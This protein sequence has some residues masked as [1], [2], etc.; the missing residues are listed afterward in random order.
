MFPG[1]GSS[2]CNRQLSIYVD[3]IFVNSPQVFQTLFGQGAVQ[4]TTPAPGN[5]GCITPG[6]LAPFGI[7]VT[8]SGPIP[9]GTGLFSDQP[10]YRSPSSQQAEFG[11]EREIA[12]GLSISA[13]YIYSHTL[14]LP[15]AIDTNLRDPGTVSATLASG[16]TVTYRDWN[17]NTAFDPLGQVTPK[18]NAAI[19]PLAP[20][21]CF[22]SP[23]IVQNNQYS[24]VASAL[25]QGG[26]LEIKRRF[27][28]HF[29]LIGSYTYSKAYD[30]TTDF[31]SD[32]GP[33]D[34]L[35]VASDRSVSNFDERH[36]FVVAGIFESP[37]RGVLSGFEASPILKYN[38]GHPFNLLSGEA[39][40]GDNHPTNGRPIGG[41]RNSGLGPNYVDADMRLTWR[42]KLGETSNFQLTAE[43][44]N[45][46]NR[47]NYASVNNEVGPLFAI[48]TALG[49][50]GSTTFNVHGS[51]AISPSQALGFTSAF[52]K[53]DV[54]LGIRFD[55]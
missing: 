19:N 1:N 12:P 22:V 33:Q 54:Q 25:Y 46:A 43:G 26:I 20:F 2:P 4:C 42:H 34:P 13:S 24:S 27:N 47:T 53:R 18:C 7:T 36:K 39:T 45:L 41:P 37:F 52:P 6:D 8:S 48:P 16:E 32:Y 49:G 23:F 17:T 21:N 55:F 14:R 10:N 31:N 44:F 35:N 9:L 28:N 3:P 5:S 40:N 29:T 51:S 30:T 15:V 38:S 50:A 11:I